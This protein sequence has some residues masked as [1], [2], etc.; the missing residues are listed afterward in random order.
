MSA[1]AGLPKDFFEDGEVPEA[2]ESDYEM[3]IRKRVEKR[4]DPHAVLRVRRELRVPDAEWER[5]RDQAIAMMKGEVPW[6]E[7]H[8]KHFVA[9]YSL[10]HERLYG[11]PAVE[12]I[13]TVRAR[14]AAM[15]SNLM[16]RCFGA[17]TMSDARA[18]AREERRRAREK[19]AAFLRWSWQR[20]EAIEKKR[21][22]NGGHG[23]LGWYRQFDGSLVT[24]FLIDQ[25]RQRR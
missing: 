20:E 4:N 24:E 7:A 19:F 18:E 13:P 16:K 11:V 17:P 3:Q 6:D 8:P 25:N 12:L 23:R 14:A 10:L 1:S 5:L 21:R 2:P 15:A 9:A 22:A